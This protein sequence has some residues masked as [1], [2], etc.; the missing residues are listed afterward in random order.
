VRAGAVQ[1]I[2]ST[3]RQRTRLFPDTRTVEEG[4][5]PDYDVSTWWGIMGPAGLPE[6]ILNRLNAAVNAAASS[7]ALEKRFADEGA[8]PQRSSPT[9]FGAIVGQE[10]E[11]WRKV[12]QD[13]G[14]VLN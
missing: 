11:N 3:A 6:P 12:V 8:D 10:L 7:P 4:G 9:E 2:G 1:L 5:V 14:L 13:G